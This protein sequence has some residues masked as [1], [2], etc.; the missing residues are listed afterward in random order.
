MNKVQKER[1]KK[2][3]PII[4]ELKKLAKKHG[5]GV[6]KYAVNRWTRSVVE[7]KSGKSGIGSGRGFP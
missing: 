4:E 7:R 6:V 5:E 1:Q 2:A 3:E